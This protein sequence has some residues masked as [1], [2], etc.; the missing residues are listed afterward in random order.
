MIMEIKD[1]REMIKGKGE[2]VESMMGG[3]MGVMVGGMGKEDF[4]DKLGE[5][6][7]VNGGVEG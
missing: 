7:F 1:F 3:K 6:G 2:R 4:E 5:G